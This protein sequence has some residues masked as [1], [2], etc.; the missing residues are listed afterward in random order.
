MF[1][2]SSKAIAMSIVVGLS[3]VGVLADYFLKLASRTDNPLRSPWLA[4]GAL[5]YTGTAF[6]WVLAM[7]HLKLASIGTVYCVSTVLLL[8]ALGTIVFRETLSG[9]EF[10]GVALA[11]VSLLLLGRQFS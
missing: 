5:V 2:Q 10:A 7:R 3:T 9:R 8:T 4:A 6:G 11:L 1:G